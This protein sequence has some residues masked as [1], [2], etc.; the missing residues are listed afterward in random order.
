M[1]FTI[2]DNKNFAK[3]SEDNNPIHTD[4][5]FAS[6]FFVKEPIVHGMHVVVIALIKFINNNKTKIFIKSLKIDFINYIHTN[7][8]FKFKFSKNNILVYNKL[9]N[10]LNISI[11]YYEDPK[12][13][14]SYDK[15]FIKKFYSKKLLN[16]SIFKELL[17]ISYYAGRIKPGAGALLN[18]VSIDCNIS[19]IDKN[20]KKFDVKKKLK[21]FFTIHYQKQFYTVNIL[22]NKLSPLN[23]KIESVNLNKNSLNRIKN[24]KILIF[25]SSSDIAKRLVNKKI[26]KICKIYKYSFRI[27]LNNVKVSQKE[28]KKIKN[29]IKKNPP[30]FIFYLS[31]PPI[32]NG[33]VKK[34]NQL[35]QLYKAIYVDFFENLLKIIKKNNLTCK[36]FYPSTIALDNF[37]FYKRLECY[38]LAKKMGEKLCQNNLYNSYVKF[39][40]IPQLISRSNYNIFGYYEGKKLSIIDYYI[41]EFLK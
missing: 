28:K 15:T 23:L 18:K 13:I 11:V 38:L 12:K 39:F 37:K 30:D 24:K 40:R 17:Y 10:K 8:D 26:E 9:N 16:N 20:K 31:S 3:K 4:F 19:K 2:T 41:N 14:L 36:I 6:K 34:N 27:N 22:A 35:F 33:N 25:G 1:K 21:N 32:F 5:K 29:F 7:E